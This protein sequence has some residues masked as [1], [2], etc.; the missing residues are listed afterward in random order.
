VG[1]FCGGAGLF[2]LSARFEIV[3]EPAPR[4]IDSL[5]GL[6]TIAHS[7]VSIELYRLRLFLEVLTA[8]GA[9]EEM[10]GMDNSDVKGFDLSGG[11][12]FIYSGGFS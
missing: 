5:V 6:R 9:E 10:R 3:G 4:A 1:I 7:P 2:G 12:N 8:E 11:F